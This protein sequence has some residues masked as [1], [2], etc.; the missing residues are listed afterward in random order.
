M[1]DFIPLASSSSACAYLV[2]S[3]GHAPL[4]IDAGLAYAELQRRLW[5]HDV[6]VSDLA[7]CLIS[8]GHG[9][10]CKAVPK[11]MAAGIDCYASPEAWEHMGLA[12]HRA[13]TIDCLLN[14]R[15]P[16]IID[17]WQVWPFEGVHDQPGTLGFLVS[18]LRDQLLYLTD[19]AYCPYRFSGLTHI[20]CEANFSSE[21]IKSSVMAGKTNVEVA[22]RTIQTHASIETTMDMLKSNDLS[23]CREIALLHLS[24]AHSDW[25][26]FRDQVRAATGVVTKVAAKN[27]GWEGE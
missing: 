12:G 24:D 25:M 1:I 7:G 19:S 27:G 8:H 11:L 14:P 15:C 18:G 10:H 9:D 21:I 6:N 20:A 17:Q 3:E 26:A 22:K 23:Q 13:K 2:K 16:I 4:L 5:K